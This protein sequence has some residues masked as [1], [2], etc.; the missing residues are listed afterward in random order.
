MLLSILLLGMVMFL[1]CSSPT[2]PIKTPDGDGDG[3]GDGTTPSTIQ[4]ISQDTYI[5]HTT[6]ESNIQFSNWSDP[7]DSGT[8]ITEDTTDRVLTLTSGTGWDINALSVAWGILEEGAGYNL[9]NV[10]SFAFS[11]KIDAQAYSNITLSVQ[12]ASSP[13]CEIAFPLSMG[14]V[15]GEWI[16]MEISGDYFN[17]ITDMKWIAILNNEDIS[18]YVELKDIYFTVDSSAGNDPATAPDDPTGISNS[19]AV[20]IYSDYFDSDGYWIDYNDPWWNP[21]VNSTAEISG[22][23]MLKY[24]IVP[25]GVEGGVVGLQFNTDVNALTS[26]KIHMDM[27]A[28]QGVS[29]VQFLLVG[30]QTAT[31]DLTS[32]SKGSWVQLDI[33]FNS[34][35]GN[36]N[37]GAIQFLGIKLWGSSGEKVYFDNIY[38]YGSAPTNTLSVNVK[39]SSFTPITGAEVNVGGTT[40]NTDSNG[41]VSF[42]L[43]DGEFVITTESGNSAVDQ[44][45]V[46]MTGSSNSLNI[47]LLDKYPGPA[48]AADDPTISDEAANVIYSD[49]L[50][51]DTNYISYWEDDW[52]NAPEFTEISIGGNNMGKFQII[53]E[54]T[55]GGI[56]GIQF[57]VDT[58]S[59]LDASGTTTLHFDMY[60][61]PGISMIKIQ[62]VGSNDMK[63]LKDIASPTT[64]QWV[65]FELDYSGMND[66]GTTTF[67]PSSLEQIGVQ[68]YGTTRDAVYMDNIYFY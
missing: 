6:E 61:T 66:I 10:S 24:T 3:D 39:D 40:S 54:G 52:W 57:G 30:G 50:T 56:T 15:N 5:Y 27:F 55:A 26:T 35:S 16:E 53:P 33:D 59:P 60:M 63:L 46:T 21:P 42:Q 38:F 34:F 37:Q 32:F 62:L 22:N 28:T 44:R 48:T 29:Q 45:S 1:G 13:A 8:A 18:G 36:F 65:S 7:W 9:S 47:T 4:T 58:Q 11:I 64:G 25:A 20:S 31:Y 51:V 68:L 49:I 2:S 17:Q 12:S 14:T 67:S 43:P 19:E 23:E 41:D